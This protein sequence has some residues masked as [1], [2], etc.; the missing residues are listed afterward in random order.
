MNETLVVYNGQ[1][2]KEKLKGL[3][4]SPLDILKFTTVTTIKFI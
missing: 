2:L 3:R 4:Q 1:D